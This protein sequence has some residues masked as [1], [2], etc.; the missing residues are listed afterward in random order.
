MEESTV[1]DKLV[2]F[3]VALSYNCYTNYLLECYA[4]RLKEK[5]RERREGEK[6]E[7]RGEEEEGEE[8]GGGRKTTMRV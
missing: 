2:I 8:K 7:I 3:F 5:E 4:G 1:S 6:R